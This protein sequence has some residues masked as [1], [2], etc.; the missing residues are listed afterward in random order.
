M[1]KIKKGQSNSAI[2][3]KIVIAIPHVGVVPFHFAL[4]LRNLLL[5]APCIIRQ[6]CSKPWDMARNKLVEEATRAKASHIF[7]LDSDMIVPADTLTKLLSRRLPVVAGNY[8]YGSFTYGSF[9]AGVVSV[10]R[11][12]RPDGRLDFIPLSDLTAGLY[13]RPG[14]VVGTGCMLI[15]MSVFS[16]LEK[17]Y[18][19]VTADENGEMIEPED[20]YFCKK[21]DEAGIPVALDCDIKCYH[22]KEGIFTTSGEFGAAS[23]AKQ[24]G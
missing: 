9:S 20:Y 15:E 14:M 19:K 3:D 7:F 12:K 21:L 6:V 18:F 8:T 4:S 16:K 22:I 17:P 2:N 10:A 1:F 24:E 11:N 13:S 5:P 23:Y